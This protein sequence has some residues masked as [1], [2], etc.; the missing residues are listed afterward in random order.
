VKPGLEF[1]FSFSGRQSKTKSSHAGIDEPDA[2]RFETRVFIIALR[3]DFICKRFGFVVGGEQRT[4][5][6]ATLQAIR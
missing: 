5:E 6:L 2:N 4:K 1:E 3:P